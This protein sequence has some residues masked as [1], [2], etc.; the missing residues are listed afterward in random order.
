[1]HAYSAANAGDGLLV[2]E[3]LALLREALGQSVEFTV[4][5]SHPETFSHLDV[6]LVDAAPGKF[7]FK[8][9]YLKLLRSLGEFDLV[10]GVG[11]GYLRAGRLEETAKSAVIH[12]PQLLAAAR[13]T[14]PTVYL[15]QSIGPVNQMMLPPLKAAIRRLDRVLVRDDRSLGELSD[16]GVERTLDLAILG[17]QINDRTLEPHPVPVVSARPVRGAVPPLVT[18]LCAQ[19]GRFDGYVQSETRGNDDRSVMA[20]IGAERILTR[21]ELLDSASTSPRVVIAVRLHAALMALRAGHF[22]IHLAYERKG[23]G[24]FADLGL[25]PYVHNVSMFEPNRVVRQVE[26]FV[27]DKRVRD[28]YR[29]SVAQAMERGNSRRVELVREIR[30]LVDAAN[31]QI[32]AGD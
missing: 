8:R 26:D 25:T 17:G 30:S 24:A 19:L 11:G 10:A 18:D 27:T 6:A 21:A 31:A 7:G 3:S 1:M 5:A 13:S 28:C 32:S 12:G 16:C 4:V 2:D 23:F 29:A 14:T 20:A 22:V 9:S 15:P